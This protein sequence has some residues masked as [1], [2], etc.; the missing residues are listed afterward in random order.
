MIA[1]RL[2]VEGHHGAVMEIRIFSELHIGFSEL[3][4]CCRT[5]VTVQSQTDYV[6][7]VGTFL[8]YGTVHNRL[9]FHSDQRPGFGQVSDS[10]RARIHRAYYA[11]PQRRSGLDG[12]GMRKNGKAVGC[13][14]RKTSE[15][16]IRDL[17]DIYFS[18]A[19]SGLAAASQPTVPA[20]RMVRS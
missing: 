8:V 12:P 6:Q 18:G 9:E 13:I 2:G 14:F 16:S 5:C 15:F 17:D 3:R 1:A 10:F 4:T 7:Q 19:A 11:N 20:A